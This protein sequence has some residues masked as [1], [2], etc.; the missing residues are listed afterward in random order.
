MNAC[1]ASRVFQVHQDELPEAGRVRALLGADSARSARQ[2]LC[3]GGDSHHRS[4]SL[5]QRVDACREER[6]FPCGQRGR[7]PG[8]TRHPQERAQ[9]LRIDVRNKLRGGIALLEHEDPAHGDFPY[10]IPEA[11]DENLVPHVQR[12]SQLLAEL[13]HLAR[14]EEDPFLPGLKERARDKAQVSERAAVR[15]SVNAEEIHERAAACRIFSRPVQL[16]RR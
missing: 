12:G 15:G 1:G 4:R 11:L 16:L 2:G 6:C 10:G 13:L 7:A 8:R 9:G 5:K 3:A 14:G